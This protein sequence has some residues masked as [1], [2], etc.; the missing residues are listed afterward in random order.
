[1]S[2]TQE[3]AT[4]QLE[5]LFFAPARAYGALSLEYYEKLLSAQFDAF[6]SYSDLTL[7]QARA[8][9]DVKDSEGLKQVVETQQKVVKEF[10]ERLQGDTKKVV[11]LSQ[12]FLQKGQQLAEQNVKS[13]SATK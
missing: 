9:V 11:D 3:K 7:A 12:E 13:A 1:M 8:W 2:K 5:S 6:R 4:Q 10:G